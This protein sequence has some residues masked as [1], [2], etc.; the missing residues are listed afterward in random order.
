MPAFFSCNKQGLLFVVLPGLGT[1]G[2]SLAAEHMLLGVQ[3]Q[4]LQLPGSRAQA[5]RLWCPG[6]AALQHM[7]SSR[8][9]DR[10]CVSHTG[11]WILYQLA[12]REAPEILE[13]GG[14][15]ESFF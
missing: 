1:A 3:A 12:I 15:G 6:L 7:G 13:V 8:T 11:R 10:T 9:R 5:Q 14:D 2:A 4:Q